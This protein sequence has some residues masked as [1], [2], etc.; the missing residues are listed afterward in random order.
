MAPVVVVMG[1]SGAGKTTVGMALAARLG[2]DFEDGDALHPD[3]NIAKMAAGVPLTDDDRWPW[4]RRV[5][6]WIDG[7]QE[8]DRSGVV[9]CSAL[10]RSY[11]DVLRG[12]DVFLAQLAVQPAVLEQ[13]LDQRTGH[14]MRA[15]MLGSQLDALEA[16]QPDENVLVVDADRPVDDV[17]DGIVAALR[18]GTWQAG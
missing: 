8:Q 16:P 13:R 18:S 9:A 2:W 11:R 4:L 17:V 6:E 3:A 1:V 5:R 15:G 7:E 12:T 14:F 10:K